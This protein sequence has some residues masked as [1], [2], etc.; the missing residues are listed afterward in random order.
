MFNKPTS[1]S[2]L[3]NNSSCLVPALGVT[4]SLIARLCFGSHFIVQ[5][6]SDKM[7]NKSTSE[8]SLFNNSSCLA[9]ALG[10]TK[11]TIAI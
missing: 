8:A 7:V 9:Q 3:F 6:K 1:D 5:P 4:K 10:V 2:G 11:Y